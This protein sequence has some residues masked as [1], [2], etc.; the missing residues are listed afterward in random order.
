MTHP[1][2]VL[3]EY[4][5]Y[6]PNELSLKRIELR[7][8]QGLFADLPLI[9]QR[10]VYGRLLPSLVRYGCYPPPVQTY[11]RRAPA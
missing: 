4:S 5:G 3:A 9:E 1:N 8:K 10:W 11:P 6:E 2:P 7:L